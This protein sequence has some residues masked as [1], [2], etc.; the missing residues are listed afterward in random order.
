MKHFYFILLLINILILGCREK[1][2]QDNVSGVTISTIQEQ[3]EN[4]DLLKDLGIRVSASENREFSFT[5]KES[6]YFYGRTHSERHEAYF[7]GWNVN[8]QRIFSDYSLLLDSL[9]L[10]RMKAEVVV[11]PHQVIR[12]FSQ[13]TEEFSL[14]D[15]KKILSIA[16]EASKGKK[17][18]ISLLGASLKYE[19]LSDN[20]AFY[21]HTEFPNVLVGL[22]VRE[23]VAS[24][25]ELKISENIYF[26]TD[27]SAK[28]Y[29]VAMDSLEENIKEMLLDAQNNH[30]EWSASRKER[31]N[32]LIQ[33]KSF[34]QVSDSSLTIA[35]RWTNLTADQLI[36]KQTGYGIYAGLPWFNDYWGRDMFISL[37][38]TCLVTG[39]GSV[40]RKILVSFADY[41]NADEKSNL[42]GRV[43]NRLRPDDVIYNTADG[44]PRF[45]IALRQY[46]QYTGDQ[47]IIP[48]L[49]VSVKRALD[50]GLQYWVDEKGYLKHD[51]ADT[52]MDAKIDG[53]IPWSARG[54]RANDVQALWLEALEAGVFFAK[55]FQKEEDVIRWQK[56]ADLLKA[57]FEKDFW[58]KE[59]GFMADRLSQDNKADFTLRPNQLFALDLLSSDSLRWAC[60]RKVS[61]TL[62]FPWGV[63]SLWQ[64]DEN[65]HPYHENWDFYHKDAAYHNGT[66]WLWN[67]GIAMQRLLEAYQTE[68]AFKLFQTM[69]ELPLKRGAVGSIAENMDAHPAPK[70]NFPR[71]TGTFLQAWSNAEFLRIWHEGFWGIRPNAVENTVLLKPQMPSSIQ[72][73]QIHVSIMNGKLLAKFERKKDTLKF[74]YK[75]EDIAPRLVVKLERFAP[76]EFQ[77]AENNTLVFEL[78]GDNLTVSNYEGGTKLI[79]KRNLHPDYL[80]VKKLELAQ[81][82][83]QG[84]SFAQPKLKKGLKSIKEKD[85]LRK[86]LEGKK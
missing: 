55:S 61:E 62:I 60:T 83:F 49:Y 27:T 3:E 10:E 50:G 79:E 80:E 23:P 46:I 54:N 8:R 36:T 22:S 57:N 45:V 85:F 84:F 47:E 82:I 56:A 43:P 31:M 26:Q 69:S 15:G 64:E 12:Q 63:S 13:I 52:W 73:N 30:E 77:V 86:K 29:F 70:T 2:I 4:K 9:P 21:R 66:I 37:A 74:E 32:A 81:K 34:V 39:Q 51:D 28:G 11:Y 33:D 65:F 6:G 78:C 17:T 1:T 53:K 68:A 35:L 38:G 42:Y 67:N 14:F 40:A 59:Q 76:V 5:D 24:L 20:I 16:L 44:T 72:N 48:L 41:Q 18:A 75:V 58:G 7:A 19:K 25:E 71:L